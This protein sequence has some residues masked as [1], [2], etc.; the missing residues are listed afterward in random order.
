MSLVL[1][2]SCLA[3]LAGL[4]FLG[5]VTQRPLLAAALLGLAVGFAP[6]PAALA[7]TILCEAA[8]V[9]FMASR[10]AGDLILMLTGSAFINAVTQPLLYALIPTMPIFGGPSWWLSLGM[11][12]LVVCLVEAGLWLPVLRRAG[13]KGGP[14]VPALVIAFATNAAS[15]LVGLILPF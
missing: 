7:V 2:G 3:G 10:F 4:I 9:A 8:V 12:E 11:A 1:L 13:M 6:A 14:V 5:A 15:T